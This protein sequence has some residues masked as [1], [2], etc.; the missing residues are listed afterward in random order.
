[1][2]IS[3]TGPRGARFHEDILDARRENRNGLRVVG[4]CPHCKIAR[5]KQ[6]LAR[7]TPVGAS[8]THFTVGVRA[9]AGV[10]APDPSSTPG[11]GSSSRHVEE[12][13]RV[14]RQHAQSSNLRGLAQVL[15]A[16]ASLGLLWWGAALSVGV[17]LWLTAAFVLLI[18]L[19]TLRVFTLMHECGHGSL[20]HR[21]LL[22]R[23]FGFILG[24]AAGMPQHV[25][26]KHHN[27]HHAHNGNWDKYRG[28][29][30]TLSVDE[31]AG[32]SAAQQ[33][34]YRWKCSIAGAPIAGFIYLIFNPRFT[35]IMGSINLALHVIRQKIAQPDKSMRTLA[36]TFTTRYW[37][38]P[39]EYRHMSWNN[40]ILLGLWAVMSH[41]LGTSM[42]FA[43]YVTS[44]SLAGGAGIV[45]FTVQHN[46]RHAYASDEEHW[47]YETGAIEGTSYL[48]LPA[49][50]NWFTAN[51]GYHHI[52]HLCATIPNYRLPM[53]HEEYPDLF[54]AVARLKLGEVRQSLGYI[55]WDTRARRIISV[56]EY[57]DQMNA[58][59]DVGPC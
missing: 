45:L 48:M 56:A 41:A 26:S 24:V 8:G 52:H 34:A 17:S 37:Q 33:F 25:W 42:F 54:S 3:G 59:P 28:P 36:A 19:F 49:W 9:G 12:Q 6:A 13:R 5:P 46:F 27:Y 11:V 39:K 21:Q 4:S 53:C 57:R 20:F 35:W 2:R 55:L 10:I 38:S 51:I 43:I 7:Q 29:Y 1:M 22:N 30:T 16:V 15:T 23:T 58:V 32:L 31:Y 47:D 44:L 40:I 14:I 50:L 18:S